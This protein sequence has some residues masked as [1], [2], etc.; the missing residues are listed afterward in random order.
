MTAMRGSRVLRPDVG[1]PTTHVQVGY[2][3]T[4]SASNA[5]AGTYDGAF[6]LEV[7]PVTRRIYVADGNRGLVILE[8]DQVVFPLSSP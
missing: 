7:D 2:F 4:W 8:G 1:D 5:T 3:N 6:A